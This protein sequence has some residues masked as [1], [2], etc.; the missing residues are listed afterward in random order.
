MAYLLEQIKILSLLAVL[1]LCSPRL[2][3]AVHIDLKDRSQ[4]KMTSL[5]RAELAG[6]VHCLYRCKINWLG[7]QF[8]GVSKLHLRYEVNHSVFPDRSSVILFVAVYRAS[9]NF[10]RFFMISWN[11]RHCGKFRIVNDANF[12][13]KEGGWVLISPPLG[14][15]WSRNWM[16]KGL[17]TA[18]LQGQETIVDAG[19]HDKGCGVWSTYFP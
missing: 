4:A 3:R 9:A 16:K 19:A 1:A 2:A 14:G 18:M 12:A 11:G 15:V 7:P 17:R 5:T 8:R 13:H 6:F 10:G